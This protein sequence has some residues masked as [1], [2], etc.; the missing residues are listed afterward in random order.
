LAFRNERKL[1]RRQC[2]AS[3]K[4]IISI[5]SPDKE[6]VVYDQKI[7][8]SDEWDAMNYGR[9]FDFSKTFTQQ[10]DELMRVVPRMSLVNMESENSEYCNP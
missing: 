4:P 10:F 8:W 7:W 2:D 1:Y 5:Y 6:Y 3:K 9:E